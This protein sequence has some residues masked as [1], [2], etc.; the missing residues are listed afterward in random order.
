ME[1]MPLHFFTWEARAHTV[2]VVH[3]GKTL[4]ASTKARTSPHP[5]PSKVVACTTIKNENIR[6]FHGVPRWTK[7]PAA[8]QPSLS[9]SRFIA[10]PTHQ[11]H[12]PRRL[13]SIIARIIPTKKT[14][15]EKKNEGQKKKKDH[16]PC[17]CSRPP[18][19]ASC[20]RSRSCCRNKTAPRPRETS[21]AGT[22]RSA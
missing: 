22:T 20:S 18:S 15:N 19:A 12:K 3:R 13:I 5:Y 2:V 8:C 11:Q 14:K 7:A 1:N 16:P 10:A 21:G 6:L 9:P 4:S 17:S